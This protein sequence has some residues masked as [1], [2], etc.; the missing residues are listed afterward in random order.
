MRYKRDS[1][2][3]AAVASLKISSF[4]EGKNI[5]YR[6]DPYVITSMTDSNVSLLGS[7]SDEIRIVPVNK[8]I[9]DMHSGKIKESKLKNRYS[10]YIP[11]PKSTMPNPIKKTYDY[12]EIPNWIDRVIHET[13]KRQKA[14]KKRKASMELLIMK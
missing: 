5:S 4:E 1:E 7:E 6:D 8:W 3:Q 14:R 13:N 2:P 9:E 11:N 12:G 10:N